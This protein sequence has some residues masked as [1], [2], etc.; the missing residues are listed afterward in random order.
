[1]GIIKLSKKLAKLFSNENTF[2]NECNHSLMGKNFDDDICLICGKIIKTE[3]ENV[4]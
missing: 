3:E 4:E 2:Q 1:M